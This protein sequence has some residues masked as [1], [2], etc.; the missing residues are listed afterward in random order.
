M[1]SMRATG[2]D[3]GDNNGLFAALTYYRFGDVLDGTSTTIAF[4]ERVMASFGINGKANR[5]SKR[6][7]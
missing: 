5:E 3:A 4:S 1:A 2:R 7:P 6:E